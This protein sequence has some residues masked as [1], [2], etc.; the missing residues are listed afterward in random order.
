VT[1][2]GKKTVELVELDRQPLRDERESWLILVNLLLLLWLGGEDRDVRQA[3][4]EHLI[5]TMQ[6][7]APFAGM[8]RAY[9]GEKCPTL[10][11]PSVPH[12][13]LEE[14]DRL[15]RIMK[16]VEQRIPEF[17]HLA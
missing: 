12:Q 4:R 14:G 10:A 5:W 17:K 3:C 2:R 11:N 15:E 6:D 1:K 9:L 8:V 7:D 16:L 13:R